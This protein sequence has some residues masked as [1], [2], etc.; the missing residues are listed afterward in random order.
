MWCEMEKWKSV[1]RVSVSS[2]LRWCHPHDVAAGG[3]W[4]Q[5]LRSHH[6]LSGSQAGVFVRSM[7]TSPNFP[8]ASSR[9]GLVAGNPEQHLAGGTR[10][11]FHRTPRQWL[12]TDFHNQL[13]QNSLQLPSR[14]R[15]SFFFLWPSGKINVPVATSTGLV[16]VKVCINQE[17]HSRVMN[18][19]IF[20]LPRGL[21]SYPRTIWSWDDT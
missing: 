12:P 6:P 13:S 8:Q 3:C 4:R 14:Q 9:P 17:A 1:T 19:R 16:S 21:L 15:T 11:P 18:Q 2:I 10:P 20:L 7:I 5:S